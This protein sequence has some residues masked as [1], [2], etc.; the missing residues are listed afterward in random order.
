MTD[1]KK[2]VLNLL[3]LLACLKI[4]GD[5]LLSESG[6]WLMLSVWGFIL[7]VWELY[8]NSKVVR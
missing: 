8:K 6:I 3:M 1:V 4:L 7:T 5:S 2:N